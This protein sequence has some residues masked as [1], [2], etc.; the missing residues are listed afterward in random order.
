M[1]QSRL[2]LY[3]QKVLTITAHAKVSL[4]SDLCRC[5]MHKQRSW[6]RCRQHLLPF[7]PGKKNNKKLLC[8][9]LM[10]NRQ[11]M[12]NTTSRWI[13]IPQRRNSP[14]VVC[15]A[16]QLV[17]ILSEEKKKRKENYFRITRAVQTTTIKKRLL[18]L[19]LNNGHAHA[20]TWHWKI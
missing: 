5:Q 12:T 3:N 8:F 11:M 13:R 14:P 4:P 17:C 18:T 2:Y 1:N 19:F 7:V 9:S 10:G 20:S 16:H 6:L 15:P